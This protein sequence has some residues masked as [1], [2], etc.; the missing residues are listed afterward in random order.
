MRTEF[1]RAVHQVHAD[2]EVLEVW[3]GGKMVGTIYAR[4]NGLTGVAE[5]RF[6]SKHSLTVMVDYGDPSVVDVRV[7][8]TKTEKAK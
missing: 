1:R 2:Q 6:I 3:T 7:D 5:V 8:T 4:S